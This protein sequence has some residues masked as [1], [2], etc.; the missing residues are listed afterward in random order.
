M[1]EPFDQLR[2][3]DAVDAAWLT[4][5][6]R[7]SGIAGDEYVVAVTARSIGTGQVGENVRF[8]LRWSSNDPTLPSSVVGKFPSTSEV[9]RATAVQVGT[10]VKEV[11]FYR[12]LQS[13][14]TLRT[15]LIHHVG[16]DPETQD[17]VILMEDVAPAR[18]GDQLT[19]CSV[20]EAE[21]AID[22]VVGLHAPTWGTESELATLDWLARPDSQRIAFM[23]DLFTAVIGGF[24]DR[25]RRRLATDVLD[26][27][28]SMVAQYLPW[29]EAVLAWGDRHG[30]CLVHGDYRLDNMLF[31]E[32]PRSSPLTVVDWQTVALGI[33]P[34]D[35]AYF[36]GASLLPGERCEHEQALVS[37]Y[38]TAVRASGVDVTATA[39]WDGYVL[40]S[41]GGLLMAVLA[42]QI[43]ERTDRGDEMFAVMA[44]RHAD[45]MTTV[46]LLDRL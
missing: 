10:Y 24:V 41:A 37:R 39:I 18:Q 32:P 25:Y 21:L 3:A 46:G 35:L 14:L 9:S 43:V 16:W 19:G 29:H 28:E 13:R 34:T 15:P 38:G 5:V 42:S 45:Q 36:I 40:G 1:G 20:A 44:E 17:F 30:W 33:G 12:H 27:A 8:A 26:V 2:N 11:G 31:G 6:L 4:S 23:D 22:G 7:E